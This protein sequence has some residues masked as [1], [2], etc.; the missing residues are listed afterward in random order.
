MTHFELMPFFPGNPSFIPFLKRCDIIS[1][2]STLGAK[3]PSTT[4]ISKD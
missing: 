3:R 1:G 4:K 2:G